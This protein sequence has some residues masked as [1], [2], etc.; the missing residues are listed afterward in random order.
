MDVFQTI[1]SLMVIAIILVGLAQRLQ[2]PAPILLIFE[3]IGMGFVPGLKDIVFDPYLML[4]IVLPPILFHSAYRIS[5]REFSRNKREIF[6]LAIGL[7]FATTFLI[8]LLFKWLFP[9]LPWALA[10]AFGAIIS[11]PDAVT[12]TVILKKFTVH[13]RLKAIL[14]G[15]SLVNDASGLVL[16]K[17]AVIALLSGSFS[18]A[19]ATESFFMM[20]IGGIAIGMVIGLTANFLSSQC[21]DSVLAVVFSFTIPYMA[22]T[23]ADALNVSGV[24]AVV[25]AGLIGAQLRITHFQSLTRLIGSNTWNI[26]TIL[27]N[28][29]VFVLI[30]SQLHL[31]TR[32]MTMEQ[33]LIYSAYAA[34][35]TA[36]LIVI[37]MI[38]VYLN[39]LVVFLFTKNK[40]PLNSLS[41][42]FKQA[43]LIGWAGMRGIISLIAALA[44]PFYLPDGSPL[45]GRDIAIFITFVVIFLTIVIPGLTLSFLIRHLNLPIEKMQDRIIDTRHQLIQ[46]AEKEINQLFQ[47]K[48]IDSSEV[49]FLINYFQA[50]HHILEISN[51]ATLDA[52]STEKARQKVLKSQHD[53]LI[54]IWKKQIIDDASFSLLERELDMEDTQHLLHYHLR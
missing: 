30:G 18:I 38:W 8:G 1:L 45:P 28:C 34:L 40:K 4:T 47:L 22:Y 53:H 29:F 12:A 19:E 51:A 15:E 17:F 25:T 35:I 42:L 10:F 33:L 13:T 44:L 7:V 16:Y 26:F 27:L 49:N 3:G 2:I 36:S 21:F 20:V 5:F 46:V 43:T 50:R 24:L 9:E 52:K 23:A 54:R 14:E 31:M 11:P 6:S 48:K 41:Q 39:S 32:Q 37:R